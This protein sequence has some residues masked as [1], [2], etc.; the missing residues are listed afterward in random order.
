MP[1]KKAL[2]TNSDEAMMQHHSVQHRTQQRSRFEP[3]VPYPGDTVSRLALTSSVLPDFEAQAVDHRH[4]LFVARRH[5]QVILHSLCSNPDVVVRDGQPTLL[6]IGGNQAE[7]LG[8]GLIAQQQL[9]LLDPRIESRAQY[10]QV[11]SLTSRIESTEIQFASDD[12][13]D[14]KNAAFQAAANI[15]ISGEVCTGNTGIE[16]VSS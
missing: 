11:F 13:R 6:Q 10:R 15:K 9:A 16:Q 1:R 3:L 4:V 5:C 8:S 2:F 14:N 12:D 7:A